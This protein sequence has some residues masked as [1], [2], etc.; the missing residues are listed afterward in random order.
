MAPRPERGAVCREGVLSCR[1]NGTQVG[2]RPATAQVT[3][4][5][6]RHIA[7]EGV[8]GQRYWRWAA[9]GRCFSSDGTARSGGIVD[10]G[11]V[12]S[13]K[14][15]PDK[16]SPAIKARTVT[17]K[18]IVGGYDRTL[19]K[20]GATVAET[21]FVICECVSGNRDIRRA[22]PLDGPA[23]DPFIAA[24]GVV[25]EVYISPRGAVVVRTEMALSRDPLILRPLRVTS[26]PVITKAPAI[27]GRTVVAEAPAP[28]MLSEAS[29]RGIYGYARL[30]VGA[31]PGHHDDRFILVARSCRLRQCLSEATG[32]GH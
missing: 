15:T 25:C 24:E 3:E 19:A 16:N 2:Y 10:E 5:R 13:D 12:G 32:V 1:N 29:E 30:I 11:V 17:A 20:E 23:V 31:G 18:C 6:R 8:V 14:G 9:L 26:P 22:V 27:P 21:R 28:V 7:E 4:V